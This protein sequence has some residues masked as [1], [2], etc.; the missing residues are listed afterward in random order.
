MNKTKISIYT[1]IV[2]PYQSNTLFITDIH[3]FF[4]QQTVYKDKF[5]MGYFKIV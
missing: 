4:S 3:N 5:F 2:Y 1:I